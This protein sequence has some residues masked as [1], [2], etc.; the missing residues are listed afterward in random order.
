MASKYG[1]SY[2]I[3]FLEVY[4]E[5]SYYLCFI[6]FR[7]KTL[8]NGTLI[9]VQWLPQKVMFVILTTLRKTD[10]YKNIVAF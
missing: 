4:Y 9:I 1:A 10:S 5:L 3:V 6:P 8:S 7:V 2:S